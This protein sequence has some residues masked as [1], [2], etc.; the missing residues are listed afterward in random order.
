MAGLTT[1]WELSRGDWRS[2]LESITVYQ[3]GWRLGGKG[4]SSRGRNGRIEEHGLHVLLGYYD[5][6]FR[7]LRECYA[8][9]DRE[10]TD[11][12]CPIR[13]W[14]QAL[15]PSGDVG[16]A[17][18]GD[19]AWA[20]FVTRITTNDLLP[21]EPGAEDLPL[22]PIEVARR[23]IG[24]L[25][26]FHRSEAWRDPLGG[27]VLSARPEPPRPGAG[28]GLEVAARTAGLTALA[29]ALEVATRSV[30]A[31]A[32]LGAPALVDAAQATLGAVREGLHRVVMGD[33][34]ARRT[35]QL[36]DLVAT[37]LLGM[38]TDRLLLGGWL[39]LDRPPRLPGVVG[40]ARCCRRDHRLAHRAG[41]VRPGVRVRGR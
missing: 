23:S 17:E 9:L 6:T 35:W 14:D 26:D 20:H 39:R 38:M 13:T 15:Q 7:V 4:A 29:V 30:D 33:P 8:E 41:H 21:G 1:A 5:A 12:G 11:P 31:A 2:E 19:G 10:R 24:L 34:A 32:L 3:R 16:L 36:V 27:V 25:L 28:S 22:S 18:P 37:N 40:Q